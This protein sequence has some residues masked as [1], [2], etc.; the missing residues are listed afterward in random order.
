MTA[1]IMC[2]LELR[3]KRRLCRR[4]WF[5]SI[6]HKRRVY[7]IVAGTGMELGLTVVNAVG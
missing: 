2:I 7:V 5:G 1:A 6:L 3:L 4:F